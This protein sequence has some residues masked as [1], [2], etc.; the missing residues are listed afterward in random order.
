MIYETNLSFIYS[1][2]H[3]AITKFP[4]DKYSSISPPYVVGMGR[5][6]DLVEKLQGTDRTSGKYVEGSDSLTEVEVCHYVLLLAR[7]H[8]AVDAPIGCHLKQMLYASYN[9][10]LQKFHSQSNLR[11]IFHFMVYQ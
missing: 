6:P 1:F 8:L 9:W 5:N 3:T 2:T 11:S 10:P 4:I 7:V